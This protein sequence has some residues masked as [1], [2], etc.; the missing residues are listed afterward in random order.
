MGWCTRRWTRTPTRRS[1]SRRSG[2][3]WRRAAGSGGEGR[4]RCNMHA[5]GS[6]AW[7]TGGDGVALSDPG[8]RGEMVLT[9]VGKRGARGGGEGRG[10]GEAYCR[11]PQQVH[12]E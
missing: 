4:G 9:T 2:R 11:R 6:R 7:T 1:C 8:A 3:E 5:A 10:H 12:M